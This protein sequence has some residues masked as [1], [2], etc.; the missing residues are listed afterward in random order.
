[1]EKYETN[2]EY[3]ISLLEEQVKKGFTNVQ[4]KGT[5]MCE[6]NGNLIILTTENQH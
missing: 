4:I 1:M 2:I 3:L 6:E 5:L